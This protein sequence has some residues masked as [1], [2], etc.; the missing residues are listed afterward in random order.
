M[1]STPA[2]LRRT[3]ARGTVMVTAPEGTATILDAYA[4][5]VIHDQARRI[6][7]HAALPAADREDV[8][9]DLRIHL[10]RQ[11]RKYDPS[12]GAWTTFARC[13]IERK[14]TALLA[15]HRTAAPT[16][17]LTTDEDLD[18]FDQEAYRQ[19]VP[20]HAQW[21]RTIDVHRTLNTLPPTDRGVARLL[22]HMRITE[23]ARLTGI[24]RSTLYGHIAR[25]RVAFRDAGLGWP[26]IPTSRR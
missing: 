13:V 5:R 20:A 19:R 16:G 26:T 4:E 17:G 14:A 23:A 7:R 11:H 6:V 2:G 3:C 9:Q 12:R 22:M 21:E 24:P 25:I 15:S 10:W 1:S 18:A 8:A